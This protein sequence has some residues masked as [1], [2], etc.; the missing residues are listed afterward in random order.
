M[1]H[2]RHLHLRRLFPDSYRRECSPEFQRQVRGHIGTRSN[3]DYLAPRHLNRS[4]WSIVTTELRVIRHLVWSREP[5]DY[6]INVS[7]QD[8]PIKSIVRIK[9]ALSAAWPRIFVE[10]MPFARIAERD[11]EDNHLARRFAFEMFGRLVVTQI[12]LPFPKS[13]DVRFKGS[14]WF[15][16]TR[17]FCE[18]MLSDPIAVEA[19]RLVKYTWMPE[20]VF[21]Q[22]VVMNSSYQDLLAEH[23]GR[24]I[25]W[26]GGQSRPKTLTM[27]DYER[28]SASSALFARKFDHRQDRQILVSLARDHGYHVPT[29]LSARGKRHER[30][31]D[32]RRS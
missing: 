19:E 15:M 1:A 4:G 16:L 10:V 25:I 23:Y 7:G 6:L 31:L 30:M 21:F 11:P 32:E 2:R 9:A 13:L 8:Y 5:F 22:V 26:P 27:E 24:A 14:G 17:E 20:E 28:L 29:R 18:W 12:R 3:V